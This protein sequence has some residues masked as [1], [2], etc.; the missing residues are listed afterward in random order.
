MAAT[1]APGHVRRRRP[2]SGF[3]PTQICVRAGRSREDDGP[4]R[5]A[6]RR[7]VPSAP[8]PAWRDLV[9]ALPL[10]AIGLA[11]T[12]RAA[13]Q[14]LDWL[15]Q[16]DAVAWTCVVVAGLALVLRRRAP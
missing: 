12:Q 10:L 11:G 14:Q 5:R 7:R 1:L 2:W 8:P 4:P 3:R 13:E 6:Y 15:R 9:P 16:P